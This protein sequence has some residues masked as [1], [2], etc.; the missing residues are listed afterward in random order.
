VREYAGPI[1]AKP[2]E[3]LTRLALASG[4]ITA[5]IPM[6]DLLGLGRSARMNMPGVP[7]GNWRWRLQ[8]GML[9]KRDAARLRS[10]ASATGR[11]DGRGRTQNKTT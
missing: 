5:I 1:D 10:L 6:Q 8:K 9:L 4:S 11:L 7:K 3:V 2:S